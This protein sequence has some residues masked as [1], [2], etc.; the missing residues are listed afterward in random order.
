MDEPVARRPGAIDR[1]LR[2]LPRALLIVCGA[3]DRHGALFPLWNLTMFAPQYPDG[4][5]LDIYSYKLEGG[6]DGPGRQGD[7]RPQPLH[8]HARPG[9][10]RT[11]P[12]SSGCR[13]S[14]ARSAL[15]F[16]RAVVHGTVGDLL[17]V[18]RALHLLRRLLALVV[19]LQALSL[20]SRPGADR[21]GQGRRRSCRRCSATSKIANFEVYSYPGAGILRAHGRSAWRCCSPLALAWRQ[22]AARTAQRGLNARSP[23]LRARLVAVAVGALLAAG[24]ASADE[25]APPAQT[26][27]VGR[28]RPRPRRCRRASTRRPR[29]PPSRSRPAT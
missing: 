14:S 20:R 4:L 12:S 13:S 22:R 24:G 6:N 2:R 7:Q 25:A 27:R 11:S 21:G 16:L 29:A 15:L 19:R 26:S 9:R 8:R 28:R 10:P 23:V 3:A 1:P 18:L 5:R 17:D